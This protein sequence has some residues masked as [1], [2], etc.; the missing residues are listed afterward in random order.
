MEQ[1]GKGD[2]PYAKPKAEEPQTDSRSVAHHHEH[3]LYDQK[4]REEARF[5][6]SDEE[7]VRVFPIDL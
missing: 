4:E 6:R 5:P 1:G 3:V 7:T 2:R